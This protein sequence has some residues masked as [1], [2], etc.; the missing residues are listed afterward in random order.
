M[1]A[2]RRIVLMLALAAALVAVGILVNYLLNPYGAWRTALIDP[3]FRKVEHE[4]VVTPYL[5]RTSAPATL[6]LGSSRVLLGMRVEQGERDDVMNGALTAATIPQLAAIVDLALERNPRLKRIVWGVD[7][8]TFDT[9]W[10]HV[11]R[12][13]NQRVAGDRA[14]KVEDTLLSLEALG[15]G[16]ELWNR[17]R[18]GIGKLPPTMI[19]PVSTQMTT[20]ASTTLVIR[21]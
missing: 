17:S 18:R 3:F 2:S 5:L 8:F 11:D 20:A 14:V 16:R 19:Q 12:S 6:L 10:N 15:D 9:V 21:L 7:F 13:F 4:R 1:N